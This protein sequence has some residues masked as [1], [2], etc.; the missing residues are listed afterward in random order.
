M[1]FPLHHTAGD[2]LALSV[3]HTPSPGLG[4]WVSIPKLGL[5]FLVLAEST[6]TLEGI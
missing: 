5:L 4:Y 3:P 2:T 6:Q 1:Q